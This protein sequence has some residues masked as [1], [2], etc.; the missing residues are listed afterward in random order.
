MTVGELIDTNACIVEAYIIIRGDYEPS[1]IT[2]KREF[3]D[4]LYVHEF[5][6]GTYATMGKYAE[7]SYNGFG[8]GER[9][10]KFKTPYTVINK[11]LNARAS[12][13]YW[14]TKLNVIPKSVLE[15][16]VGQWS[17]SRAYSWIHRQSQQVGYDSAE[18]INIIVYLPPEQV[19]EIRIEAEVKEK[20]QNVLEGQMNL[21]EIL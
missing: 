13:Q 14:N 18:M 16:E 17:S 12:N 3:K 4:S 9:G 11:E 6:I 5:A 15:L 10:R 2:G 19:T 21:L 7:S 20:R 1:V 8:R